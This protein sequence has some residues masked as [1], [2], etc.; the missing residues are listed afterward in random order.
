[1]AR[2]RKPKHVSGFVTI[3]GRPNAGKSTLLNRIAGSKLAI[4]ADKPQTTR[5]AIQ[6]VLTLPHAQVI[7]V[8]TP[9]VHEPRNLLNRKMMD[10]VRASTR[11]QDLLIWLADATLPFA[12]SG[13]DHLKLLAGET[14]PAIVAL[15]KIDLLARKPDLIPLLDAY[16]KAHPFEAFVPLSAETG[17]GVDELLAEIL[18]RMPKGPQYYPPDYLTDQPMRFLAAELVR[19][20]VLLA[21]G[22]EVPHSVAVL[23]EKW[24]ESVGRAHIAA[25]IHV[26]RDGQKPI[27]IGRGGEMLKRIGTAARLQIEERL[28]KKVFLEL[29]VRVKRQWRSSADF[30]H[31][32][33]SQK[34]NSGIES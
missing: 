30:L 7:F 25:A 29:F 33:E 2:Q 34:M 22:Q 12:E 17:E 5:D 20:Q 21:T 15:N 13:G 26:E 4:V 3:L 19:E 27:I 31:E 23:I 24:D 10:T 32:L 9:G 6:A 18:K 8:D 14:I 11:E 16:G 1:M 28:G